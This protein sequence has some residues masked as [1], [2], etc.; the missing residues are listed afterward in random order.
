MSETAAE[1]NPPQNRLFTF[2]SGAGSLPWLLALATILLMILTLRTEGRIWWCKWDTP[3][4]FWTFDAWSKHTSQHFIDPYFFTH[5]LHGFLFLWFLDLFFHKLLGKKIS[6]AWLLFFA[7]LA[8]SFWEVVE[9]SPTVIERYRENTASLDY[10]G[11]SIANSV[12]DIAACASGFI[13]A[14]GLRFWRS[15]ALFVVVEIF[16]ILTIRDSLLIN[17]L[18]LIHPIDAIKVWQTGG[19]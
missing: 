19:G 3:L 18:M 15:L 7:V 6:F 14:Y 4:H 8:E 12:G 9:N 16:L 17:I 5:I 10:F 11:D 2:D 13:I 1:K